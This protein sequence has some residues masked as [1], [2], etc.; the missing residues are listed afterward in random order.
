MA[1]NISNFKDALPLGGAR[2]GLFKIYVPSPGFLEGHGK[3]TSSRFALS[4]QA[5]TIPAGTIEAAE[6]S[7]FGRIFKL[8][9]GRVFDEWATTVMIDEDYVTRDFIEQWMDRINGNTTNKSTATGSY[10]QDLEV[11]QYAKTGEIVRK[12][13]LVGAW[14]SAVGEVALDW[15]EA[16]TIQ[17]F[18]VSWQFQWW[19]SKAISNKTT[20]DATNVD[21]NDPSGLPT[22][23]DIV[24]DVKQAFGNII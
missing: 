5:S 4:A 7:Y 21:T 14:P 24:S 23:G 20:G 3:E 6:V 13:I 10:L 8:P 22:V 16:S 15:A 11:H 1:F 2:A 18:D 19:E 12:Y 9:G 17:T